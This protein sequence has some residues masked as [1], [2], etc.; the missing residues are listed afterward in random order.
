MKTTNLFAMTLFIIGA[1][2]LASARGEPITIIGNVADAVARDTSKPADGVGNQAADLTKAALRVG[3]FGGPTETNNFRDAPVFVFELPTLGAGELLSSVNFRVYL[4]NKQDIGVG[5]YDVDLWALRV[6]GGSTVLASDY[7]AGPSPAGP[8]GQSL[9]QSNFLVT[10]SPA[11]RYYETD[12]SARSTL[13]SFINS[14]YINEGFVFIRLNVDSSIDFG[15]NASG[16]TLAQG[17]DLIS[18]NNAVNRPELV[19]A[20]IPEPST[21]VLA[22]GAVACAVMLRRI[23]T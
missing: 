21:A 17:Y 23:R 22:L 13:T 11:G 14:N 12:E 5:S 7:G 10:G 18:A 20:V 2:S 3:S 15:A 1:F 16:G 6:S 8:A 19:V 4:G 9:L